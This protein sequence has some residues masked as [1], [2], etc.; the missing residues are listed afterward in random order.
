MNLLDKVNNKYSYRALQ[1]ASEGIEQGWQR[2][3]NCVRLAL[4]SFHEASS[5]KF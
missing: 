1:F 2:K 5:K 4:I 3:E